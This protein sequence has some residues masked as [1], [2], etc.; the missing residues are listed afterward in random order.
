MPEGQLAYIVPVAGSGNIPGHPLPQ[1]PD[2]IW[3]PGNLPPLPPG[4]KPDPPI[5]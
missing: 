1:P 3:P 4:I 5:I 2:V